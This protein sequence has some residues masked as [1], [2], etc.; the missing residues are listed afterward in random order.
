MKDHWS[1]KVEWGTLSSIIWLVLLSL[2]SILNLFYILTIDSPAPGVRN[3]IVNRLGDFLISLGSFATIN[4]TLFS[5]F[6]ALALTINFFV[7]YTIP[8]IYKVELPA[9]NFYS[10]YLVTFLMLTLDSVKP[11]QWLLLNFLVLSFL[12]VVDIWAA[13]KR[14]KSKVQDN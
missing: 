12:V 1:K 13:R 2:G 10:N 7:Y 11:A 6:A 4:I 9:R 5:V 3:M 8:Y 14:S